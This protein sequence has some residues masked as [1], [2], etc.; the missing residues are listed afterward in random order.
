MTTALDTL[1]G[2]ALAGVVVIVIMAVAG[3]LPWM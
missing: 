2:L 3:D 1:I